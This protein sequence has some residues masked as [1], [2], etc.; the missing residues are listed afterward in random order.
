[1]KYV[2]LGGSDLKVSIVCLVRALRPS[3]RR[4]GMKGAM[5]DNAAC[6]A[7]PHVRASSALP[8]RWPLPPCAGGG[9][10]QRAAAWAASWHPP[11]S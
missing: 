7:A 5:Y 8:P 2:K 10:R 4:T 6:T 1:M 3:I 11:N 9:T